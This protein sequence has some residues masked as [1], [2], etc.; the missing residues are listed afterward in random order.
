[1]LK[2]LPRLQEIRVKEFKSAFGKE[3]IDIETEWFAIES[4]GIKSELFS[5]FFDVLDSAFE[6]VS[7][8]RLDP[9]A[10]VPRRT[11]S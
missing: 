9:E 11:F 7:F 4:R 3:K 2:N 8:P 5:E 1:M 10:S 6:K